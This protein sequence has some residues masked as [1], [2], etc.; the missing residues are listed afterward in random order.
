MRLMFYALEVYFPYSE[1][2]AEG[3]LWH[4][5]AEW[6]VTD[7]LPGPH[8]VTFLGSNNM[9][10]CKQADRSILFQRFSRIW[11][12]RVFCRPP[13][14]DLA[15][16]AVNLTTGLYT[17][18]IC[19]GTSRCYEGHGW[20]YAELLPSRRSQALV[21][22]SAPGACVMYETYKRIKLLVG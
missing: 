21:R 12:C 18:N 19:P 14:G 2:L 13:T 9:A 10:K 3:M 7:C 15:S 20:K 4:G 11:S 8:G 1:A 6:P 5:H 16:R 22:G 17:G